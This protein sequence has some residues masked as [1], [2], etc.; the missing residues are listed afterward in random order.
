MISWKHSTRRTAFGLA[1]ILLFAIGLVADEGQTPAQGLI[2][3]LNQSVVWYRQLSL[4]QQL[5]TAPADV[6]FLND[7]RQLGDQ[8]VALSFDFARAR[9]QAILAQSSGA[10]TSDPDTSSSS[11]YQNLA[12]LAAQAD[13]QVKQIQAE[14]DSQK[15]QLVD[16]TGKKRKMLESTIAETQSEL[17]LIQVRRDTLRSMIQFVSGA[18][19]SGAGGG[20][21]LSQIEEL[22]RTVP[23]T[24]TNK[25]SGSNSAGTQSTQV[26]V[27]TA[28]KPEPTG[29]LGLSSD[30]IALHRKKRAL[31]DAARSTDALAKSSRAMMTPMIASIKDLAKRGNDISSAPDSTDPAVL[32]Q[33]KK[34][35]DAMTAQYKQLSASVLPLGK[36]SVLLDLYKRS[37]TNWRNAVESE[38]SLELRGLILRLAV[39][40]AVLAMV[41]VISEVWRR[42][43]FRYVQ[44]VRRRYQ[45]LLLRRIMVWFLVAIIIAVAFASELGSLATFAGLLTAGVA[46]ALQN[47]ILSVAGYF[48]LIGKYGVRVGDR[49]QVAGVT[50]DV[51]DIGLVR[52][53]LMEVGGSGS[54]ARPTGRV[55]VFSNAVVF[56]ANAGLFKQI[57]GTKFVW[58]EITLTLASDSDY[59]QVEDRMLG[60]VKKVY[61]EYRDDME[62]QRRTMERSLSPLSVHPM[63]PESRLRLTQSGLEVIIR[64]PVELDKSA[65]I[66]DRIARE[67]LDV[68]KHDPKLKVIGSETPTIEP[69]EVSAEPG[70]VKKT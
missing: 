66:D 14:L 47:V 50:G 21:L 62:R 8:I 23:A 56:Q 12:T 61:D 41:F 31:D 1:L 54:S 63:G 39:L 58:H 9:A 67:L 25:P 35:L 19:A 26:S 18:S 5:A 53:H 43:T 16:A 29:I 33:Q 37:L 51:I 60:A 10:T 40:A 4:Q 17:E 11:R 70:P 15:Q 68:T 48:F 57:P 42:A 30:L 22:A 38:Y 36:Q 55:V 64:Y 45:F 32:A 7:D 44:D 3:F 2:S 49:V 59:H 27:P 13:N 69:A 46:V 52:L 28:Q 20:G 34:E 65:E 24:A 6:L